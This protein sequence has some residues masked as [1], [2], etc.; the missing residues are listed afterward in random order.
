[1][2]RLLSAGFGSC[3][4]PSSPPDPAGVGGWVAE[5]G[6]TCGTGEHSARLN[7]ALWDR[8]RTAPRQNKTR[9]SV[10]SVS[11]FFLAWQ[12][13]PRGTRATAPRAREDRREEP[14][15]PA[16]QRP[17]GTAPR[18]GARRRGHK[19][20]TRH[21]T[22]ARLSS[23]LARHSRPHTPQPRRHPTMY[24]YTY[25][26]LRSAD[27]DWSPHHRLTPLWTHAS[28]SPT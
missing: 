27:C 17:T 6:G 23:G 7:D 24:S 15:R 28:F 3:L 13:A 14:R 16:A 1:M 10:R 21:R 2:F 20:R 11:F 22:T 19:R 9:C 8:V 25:T 5:G 26:I 18:P 12:L 4:P